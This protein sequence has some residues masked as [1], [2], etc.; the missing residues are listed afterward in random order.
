MSFSGLVLEKD[1]SSM[2]LAGQQEND[3]DD[4][5]LLLVLET[6]I[7]LMMLPDARRDHMKDQFPGIVIKVH[8]PFMMLALRFSNYLSALSLA[9]AFM[10]SSCLCLV[11]CEFDTLH[12]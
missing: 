7:C 12:F 4:V 9:K 10:L 1:A 5:L 11:G 6:G 3:I 8:A 2:I